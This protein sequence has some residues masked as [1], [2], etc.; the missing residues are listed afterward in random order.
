MA[1]IKNPS[2]FGLKHSRL[3]YGI[4]LKVSFPPIFD[5]GDNLKE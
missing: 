3:L 1:S 2:G 4:F 5:M